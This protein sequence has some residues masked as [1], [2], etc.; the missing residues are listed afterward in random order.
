MRSTGAAGYFNHRESPGGPRG[1]T[2]EPRPERS[3]AIPDS[4]AIRV[5]DRRLDVWQ[6]RVGIAD[7]D[8][9]WTFV[10]TFDHEDDPKLSVEQP[11]LTPPGADAYWI[12]STSSDCELDC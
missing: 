1:P 11:T 8:G 12:Y 3:D 7:P 10:E 5:D 2:P 6:Y 9:E 4:C